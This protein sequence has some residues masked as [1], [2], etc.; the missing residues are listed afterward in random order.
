[1]GVNPIKQKA[2]KVDYNPRDKSILSTPGLTNEIQSGTIDPQKLQ[3]LVSTS[4]LTG[5][6][7]YDE[8]IDESYDLTGLTK[9]LRSVTGPTLEEMFS[10]SQK[11][12]QKLA[13]ETQRDEQSHHDSNGDILDTEITQNQ[14]RLVDDMDR[15]RKESLLLTDLNNQKSILDNDELQDNLENNL[16]NLEENHLEDETRS[17]K[18]EDNL[19][20]QSLDQNSPKLE[21][22]SLDDLESIDDETAEKGLIV[23][24]EMEN[25]LQALDNLVEKPEMTEEE[26]IELENH[27]EQLD[28]NDK[29]AIDA[30]ELQHDDHHEIE[31]DNKNAIE[32]H[33]LDEQQKLSQSQDLSEINVTSDDHT[34]TKEENLHSPL[35]NDDISHDNYHEMQDELEESEV[36]Q[37]A[38]LKSNHPE[39]AKAFQ[40]THTPSVHE[41]LSNMKKDPEIEA[42]GLTED[43]SAEEELEL[44]ENKLQSG[45]MDHHPELRRKVEDLMKAQK[46]LVNGTPKWKS[47][48]IGVSKFKKFKEKRHS[49]KYKITPK[50]ELPKG[51]IVYKPKT[52][53]GN[54]MS[55]VPDGKVKYNSGHYNQYEGAENRL[56]NTPF[57]PTRNLSLIKVDKM[58]RL[59]KMARK[60][61]KKLLSRSLV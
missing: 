10:N 6:P 61:R 21:T 54:L 36:V 38:L 7:K 44:I 26:L 59:I 31:T 8:A 34:I 9:D 47:P 28:S 53:D 56:E 37:K 22:E 23:S 17:P 50:G 15:A 46:E 19:S 60:K 20:H 40:D 32:S 51:T 14:D 57:D 13:M 58:P 27:P 4:T 55:V 24:Q 42:L 3:N 52:I 12:N 48:N 2:P 1:M 16:D 29:K 5:I 30:S 33:E 43:M 45:E 35:Y 41:Q 25:E 49:T 39:L 18:L 11:K